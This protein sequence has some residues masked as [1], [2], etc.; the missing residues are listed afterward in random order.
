[1]RVICDIE[2]DSL[3]PSVIWVIVCKDIDTQ[4]VKV[5]KRPDLYPSSFV[6]YSKNV[7]LWVGHNFL[8]YD[9]LA[10]NSLVSGVHID[11]ASCVDT[12]IVSRLVDANQEGG[13]S[14]ARW[15]EYLGCSKIEFNDFSQLT[16]EM[17]EYC[18]QDV[19][20]NYKVFKHLEKFIYSPL[21]KN[22]L[23][24]EHE[25][26]IICNELHSNG[27]Y[28]DYSKALSLY[29]DI[30]GRLETLSLELTKAFP[31]RS[32]LIR[33][34][35]PKVTKYGTLHKGDFRWITD[36][37]LSVYTE[38]ASFSRI[39]W[40]T[41][42]PNSQKQVIERLNEAGWK[43][44]EKTKGH[45]KVEREI[46]KV[47]NKKLYEQLKEKLDAYQVYGWSVSEENLN[48]LPDPSTQPE[49]SKER[50]ALES[51]RKL[52]Q[53]LVLSSRR[54]TLE[55]W[56][57]A[58]DGTS[59]RIHGTFHHI[60]AWT[61]R[62]SHS[63][64]NM[65]NISTWHGLPK[66]KEPTAVELIKDAIDPNMRK[67][68]AAPPG[69]LLVGVD[70]DSIQL[71]ILA[72]YMNDERFIQSLVSGDK[73]NGTDAHTLN[74]NALNSGGEAICK[75]RDD[76]KTFIYAWLLGAGL[77]KVAQILGCTLEQARYAN[78]SFL[79]YYPGLKYLKTVTI[80]NDAASGYFQ[81]FDG[82]FVQ[83]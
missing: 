80:P 31:P 55:E 65:A 40:V 77:Q 21:W 16:K 1:M 13:H 27:F 51:A 45:L 68:W 37:N 30:K 15:G 66:D 19:E 44:Y 9:A 43:P 58:Y 22:S 4:E 2:A 62:M 36:G 26:Q 70:A 42:N 57:S 50:M 39:E 74:Q 5:F 47:R 46:R 69:K 24:T 83:K 52:V 79:D 3:K 20:V 28:F 35:T 60:G 34:I 25:M 56:F 71:R 54:S 10:I 73:K 33:E 76:A 81:G 59:K 8:G 48:T 29:E 11:F 12:L 14:L 67:V 75:S 32:K 63:G 78:D 7:S 23:R 61:H 49:G 82:R 6:S 18:K 41:F 64:P 17:I 53:W 38:G 72:H